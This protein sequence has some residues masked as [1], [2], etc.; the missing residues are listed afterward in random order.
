[1]YQKIDLRFF[2]T[3]FLFAFLSCSLLPSKTQVNVV[4]GGMEIILPFFE[5]QGFRF[6]QLS[7]SPEEKP[8]R[9]LV[10]TGSRFSFL[11]EKFFNE[12]DS[13]RR[14]A[15]TYPGGKD[16]SYRKVRTIQLFSKS[17]SVF[18][19]LTVLSHSFA[20]NLELDGILGMDALYEKILI[21]EYPTQIRFLESA[22]G[23]FTEAMLSP[24]PGLA[25]N[26]E[27]LRFFSGHP[28]LEIEYG[29]QEKA[30]LLMDTGADL[31]LL[32]L[33]NPIPGFVEETSSSRPV[34]ILNFQG[35]VLNV[36][37][38]FVRKLCILATSNC[39]NDLEILPSGLPVDF[40]GVSTGVRIQGILGVNW[41]NEHRILLDMKRSLIGIVGKDGG[42]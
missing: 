4:S 40:A 37:T 11:D 17:H 16:D 28:V 19:D 33:P 12:Q 32:E 38:R 1:M 30:L 31:S 39:V 20:G 7:L 15:V 42:K 14:I 2:L 36:R 18:K 29:T 24:F 5:K 13:K 41:L 22:G 23:E 34:Q 10:D 25:Q 21:L 6:I 3:L 9:F 26:T 27:P 35:K 8:L